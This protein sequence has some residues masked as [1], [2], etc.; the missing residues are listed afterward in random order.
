VVLVKFELQTYTEHP[1]SWRSGFL[2][3]FVLLNITF[4]CIRNFLLAIKYLYFCYVISVYL[5]HICYWSN[6]L[7]L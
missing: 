7:T 3:V 4:L 1:S 6:M 2:V 5:Y